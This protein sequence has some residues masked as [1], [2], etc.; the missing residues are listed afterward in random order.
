MYRT[1]VCAIGNGP[2]ETAERILN[3]AAGLLDK[4]GSIFVIHAV[5]TM[6]RYMTTSL[7]DDFQTAAI[8]D[9]EAKLTLLCRQMNIPAFIEVHAGSAARVLL[10]AA[11]EKG[12]DLIILSTHVADITDYIFGAV[13]DRVV[14]HAKCSVLV[15]RK[16]VQDI[17]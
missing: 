13:V 1:I 7:P 9:A 2:R 17:S 14:R 4:D 15:D 5:E 6:P 3:K 8:K 16:K 11:R 10:A 12:A